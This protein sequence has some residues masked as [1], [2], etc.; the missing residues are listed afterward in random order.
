MRRSYKRKGFTLLELL[1]VIFIVSLVYFIGIEGF[2]IFK[3][4][5][6]AL[7]LANLK[8]NIEHSEQFH[9]SAT[10]LCTDK[11]R[12]CYLRRGLGAAFVR[13]RSPVALENVRA[14]TLDGDDQLVELEYGRFKDKKICLVVQFY[15]NGSSTPLILENEKGAYFLPSFFGKA[16]RFDTIEDAKAYWLKDA[17]VLNDSGAYYR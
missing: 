15:R 3:P 16:K 11:C 7:T 13:Y 5:P 12:T 8:E 17:Y 4:K 1:I 10:L 9:K 14:Y 6:K 2:E